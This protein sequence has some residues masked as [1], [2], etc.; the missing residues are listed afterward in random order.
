LAM[1][2]KSPLGSRTLVDR[3][4]VFG[5]NRKTD[6][7]PEETLALSCQRV[8]SSFQ[9]RFVIDNGAPRELA[10]NGRC[11]RALPL[12]RAW[13]IRRLSEPCGSLFDSREMSPPP[14]SIWSGR[15]NH[16]ANYLG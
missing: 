4:S 8:P 7:D 14:P 1:P 9:S 12:C 3:R 13:S 2:P 10:S 6:L 15:G 11:P 16:S 5:A